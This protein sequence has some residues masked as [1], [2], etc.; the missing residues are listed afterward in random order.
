MMKR[1][2]IISGLIV[3]ILS[4]PVLVSAQSVN[5]NT[6]GN[7]TFGQS[8]GRGLGKG[9]NGGQGKGQGR[10]VER[11]NSYIE[12]AQGLLTEENKNNLKAAIDKEAKLREDIFNINGGQRG[13][14]NCENLPNI[15]DEAKK[16]LQALRDE[17]RSL[18]EN[19]QNI[20]QEF[21]NAVNN[22]YKEATNTAS[23]KLTQQINTR[24]SLLQKK[25]DI[26]NKYVK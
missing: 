19:N 18:R 21:R 11:L 3:S 7:K 6:N 23:Q 24:I 1:K 2:M 17:T 26:L 5:S 25:V 4:V 10:R 9:R 15:T 13:N 8:Q 20:M 16:E 14:S 12:E 22:K